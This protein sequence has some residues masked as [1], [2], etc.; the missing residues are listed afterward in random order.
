MTPEERLPGL[1]N[2]E[3]LEELALAELP[4]ELW[5]EVGLRLGVDHGASHT[6]EAPEARG[7]GVASRRSGRANRR[8]RAPRRATDPGPRGSHVGH[9]GAPMP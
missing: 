7:A 2:R 4:E 9:I 6:T 3:L 1:S 5:I 8:P